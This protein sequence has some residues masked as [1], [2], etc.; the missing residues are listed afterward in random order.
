MVSPPLATCVQPLSWR[1]TVRV[2]PLLS[3]SVVVTVRDQCS[4]TVQ[5]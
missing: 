2:L 4:Y 1:V 5:A 3:V